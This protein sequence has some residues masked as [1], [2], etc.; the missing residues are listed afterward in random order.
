VHAHHSDTE[1]AG[2]VPRAIHPLHQF[3]QKL[4]RCRRNLCGLVHRP[5]SSLSNPCPMWRTLQRAAAG[6]IR[7]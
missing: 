6:F 3:H 7:Q 5:E 4:R 1:A 2:M